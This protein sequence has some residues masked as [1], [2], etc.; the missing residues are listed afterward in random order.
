MIHR[1]SLGLRFDSGDGGYPSLMLLGQLEM[2]LSLG[3]SDK[4]V[5]LMPTTTLLWHTATHPTDCCWV[6]TETL[7]GRHLWRRFQQQKCTRDAVV[8]NGSWI[9]LLGSGNAPLPALFVVGDRAG[10]IP[11]V[12]PSFHKC[13]MVAHTTKEPLCVPFFGK[14]S[15]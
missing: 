14:D 1:P 7:A 9:G 5:E 15:V 13:C 2:L 3:S 11:L 4:V 10:I 8:G 6:P 12:H